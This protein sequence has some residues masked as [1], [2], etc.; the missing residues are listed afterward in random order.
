MVPRALEDREQKKDSVCVRVL[1]AFQKA[2][3]G[4]TGWNGG[5]E[6]RQALGVE[7]LTKVSELVG[8][9]LRHRG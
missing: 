1:T 8:G 6:D 5:D 4:R 9:A 3:R 7:F 2:V